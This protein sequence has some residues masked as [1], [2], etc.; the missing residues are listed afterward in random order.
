MCK[1]PGGLDECNLEK[2]RLMANKLRKKAAPLTKHAHKKKMIWRKKKATADKLQAAFLKARDLAMTALQKAKVAMSALDK[3]NKTYIAALAAKKFVSDEKDQ[4]VMWWGTAENKDNEDC[5][6]WNGACQESRCCQHGCGCI[7]KNAFY[8]Q[9]GPPKGQSSCSVEIAKDSAKKHAIKATGSKD[10]FSSEDA[11]KAS[12]A[13]DA[14][15]AKEKEALNKCEKEHDNA[16]KEYEKFHAD[17]VE[18]EK[19]RD[20]SH[21]A[22]EEAKE[23]AKKAHQKIGNSQI[24]ADTWAKAAKAEVEMDV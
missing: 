5:G 3:Q 19:L 13:A 15:A 4:A 18:A 16:H 22:A 21:K 10:K 7:W 23:K 20:A 24:A 9:C 1:A 17:R 12:K 8:S 2:A 11:K 6:D 14:K